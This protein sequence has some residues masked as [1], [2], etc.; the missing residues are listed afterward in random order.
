MASDP[1]VGGPVLH[2]GD[3][4]LVETLGR[5]KV[6]RIDICLRPSTD[7]AAEQYFAKVD[8]IEL[9]EHGPPFVLGLAGGAWAYGGQVIAESVEK[10]T[11]H[12]G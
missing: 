3:T 2:V 7:P 12:E 4:I 8:A 10:G 5:A 1:A 9:G 11:E 6:T